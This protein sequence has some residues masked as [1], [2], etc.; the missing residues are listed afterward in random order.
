MSYDTDL[1]SS[2]QIPQVGPTI[3]ENSKIVSKHLKNMYETV[4]LPL[5]ETFNFQAYKNKPIP[6]GFFESQPI[7]LGK[8]YIFY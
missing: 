7:V 5:E 3:D 2:D 1:G 6:K 8:T 4:V